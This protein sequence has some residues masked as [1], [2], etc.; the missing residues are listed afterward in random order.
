V[1]EKYERYEASAETATTD[2]DAVLI[3]FS[4][5]PDCIV[6]T[7]RTAGALFT[8]SDRHGRERSS[9]AVLAGT[10]QETH[11]G[12]ERVL[13]RSLVAGT[14]ASAHALGKWAE[15]DERS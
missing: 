5:R 9:I 10:S 3:D 14:P 13:V 7:A 6:L 15:P 1:R 11:I 4:G 8:I 2:T 12:R